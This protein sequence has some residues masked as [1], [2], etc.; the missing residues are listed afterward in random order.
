MMKICLVGHFKSDLDEGVRSVAKSIAKE[1]ENTDMII[2]KI[3]I[4]SISNWKN[5]IDFNPDIIHFILTP[6]LSGLLVAKLISILS[7]KSKIIISAIHPS[8]PQWNILKF[9]KPDLTLVQSSKS[10]LIFKSI[11]FETNFMYNGIDIEKFKPVNDNEKKELR[12]KYKVPLDKFVILHLASLKRER[13]L[14]VFKKIQK[15]PGNH[16]IIIGRENEIIDEDLASE[17]EESGCEVWIK[18]FQNIEEIYN[19]SDCYIFP[20][21]DDNACIETPLS[22]LESMACNLPVIT[23]KFGAIPDLFNECNGLF[24]VTEENEIFTFINKIR[25]ENIEIG[26]RNEVSIYSLENMANNLVNI[27][28]D[29]LN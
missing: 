27:Y 12:K 26:T 22:V 25:N 14:D 24:Y 21:I 15:E 7:S 3:D 6:T 23:T 16:V 8:V 4:N 9:L 1:L 2:K 11:G 13:N 19:L 5:I 29:L 20:T 28:T 18:H 10:N 17:L